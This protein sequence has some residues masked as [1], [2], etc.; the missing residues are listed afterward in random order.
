[1]LNRRPL[2]VVLLGVYPALALWAAN[3]VDVAARDVWRSLTVSLLVVLLILWLARWLLGDWPRAAWLTTLLTLTFFTYGHV[4]Q[5]FLT[6][7]G[8]GHRYLLPI[9]GL[10]W[11]A[12]IWWSLRRGQALAGL[13][14]VLNTMALVALLG[15][16]FAIGRFTLQAASAPPAAEPDAP[17]IATAAPTLPDIYYIILDGYG[18]ADRLQEFYGYDNQPFL[19]SLTA[20]G[21]Y[22]A[23]DSRSNYPFTYLSLL[24][25]L[26]YSHLTELS[27]R[28]GVDSDVRLYHWLEDSQ[29]RRF[30]VERGYQTVAISS[31]YTA[32]EFTHFDHYYATYARALNPFETRLLNNAL[33]VIWRRHSYAAQRERILFAFQK[34]AEMPALPGPKFVFTHILVPH[35]PFVFGPQG[36][37]RTP[38]GVYDTHDAS[39]YV[40]TP[41]EYRQGYLDQLHYINQLVAPTLA[42]LIADSPTPPVIVVQGDHGPGA[43]FDL[44]SAEASCLAERYAIFN[45]YYLPGYADRL[46]PGITPVNTFRLIFDA[47]WGADLPLLPDTSYFA[48]YDRPYAFQDVTTEAQTPGARCQPASDL[49]P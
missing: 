35:P 48:P 6:L 27:A 34:L 17:L 37:A 23:G 43:L 45:A 13:T 10:A 15:P 42:R 3:L 2:Y 14:P 41:A 22:V 21:F 9:W 47:Y 26:N 5:W 46:Y 49:S 20:E 11:G 4:Y 8:V 32:T 25:S 16:L 29:A 30:L 7:T 44:F 18:R 24:S 12:V 33:A 39:L 36:E 40:G 31:G 19:Q 38:G 1:M 28:L